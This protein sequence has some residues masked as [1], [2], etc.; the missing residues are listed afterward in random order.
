MGNYLEFWLVLKLKDNRN[1]CYRSK[2]NGILETRSRPVLEPGFM[3]FILG[4]A[5]FKAPNFTPVQA[6]S[7]GTTFNLSTN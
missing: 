7:P 4:F 3:T 2:F 1:P 5:V 6:P